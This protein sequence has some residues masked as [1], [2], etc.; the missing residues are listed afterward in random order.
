MCNKI[1]MKK[2]SVSFF[3]IESAFCSCC[4]A[5]VIPSFFFASNAYYICRRCFVKLLPKLA[6]ELLIFT[7][8]NV[9]SVVS[10]PLLIVFC[11]D[12]P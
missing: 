8:S 7:I 1:S 12:E 9:I 5:R 11:L 10:M 6:F 3:D 4:F 2:S